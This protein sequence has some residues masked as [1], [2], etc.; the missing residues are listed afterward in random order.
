MPYSARS[1]DLV[2]CIKP[3]SFADGTFHMPGH[4]LE[5]QEDSVDYFGMFSEYLPFRWDKETVAK[6]THYVVFC[7]VP[8]V[9]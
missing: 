4:I 3:V 6:E 5:V 2:V 7:I 8:D 9:S 1:G